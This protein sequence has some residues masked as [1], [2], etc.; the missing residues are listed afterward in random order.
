[1]KR[2][3][4]VRR[5]S[6]L[7]GFPSSDA[8]LEQVSTPPELAAELLESALARGDLDSH[9]VLDL[10]CGPGILSVG[11]ALLGARPVTGIDL[12]IP[13]L[14]VARTNALRAR[15]KG[16]SFLVQDAADWS[17]EVETVLMNPPFGAQRRHAD[18]PFWESAL[19]SATRSI[20]AFASRESRTFIERRA[21]ARG[22]RIEENRPVDW[23]FPATFPHHRKRVVE[24]PVDLW[25]LR[26]GPHA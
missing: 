15:V 4:L 6:A 2:S 3:D 26:P 21:V 19:S 25:I 16:V 24:L 7:D 9:S 17:G 5:L 14:A 23:A 20:H 22:A 11:A 18:R 13:A 12:D 1:M 10:G 8:R